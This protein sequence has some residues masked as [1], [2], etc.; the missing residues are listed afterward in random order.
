L[1]SAGGWSYKGHLHNSGFVGYGVSIAS[2][3]HFKDAANRLPAFAEQTHLGGTTSADSRDHDI[4]QAGFNSIIRENWDTIRYT[5]MTTRLEVDTT[6]GDVLELISTAVVVLIVALVGHTIYLLASGQA[7][8]CP[9]RGTMKPNPTTPG[10]YEP[11][12][13]FPIVDPND[14]CP[15]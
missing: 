4:E 1:N 9:A 10:E 8:V 11:T 6:I 3:L 5:G 13:T 7:K 15:P 12:V 14:P 2:A